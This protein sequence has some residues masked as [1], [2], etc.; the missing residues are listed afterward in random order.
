ME[1][2]SKKIK[3]KS[4]NKYINK[5]KDLIFSYNLDGYIVPKNDEYFSEYA[6]PDRLQKISNFNGSAGLAIILINKN[7]LFVD[8]RYTIQAKKQAGTKFKII[9]IPNSSPKE[10]LKK[11]K[12]KMNL[13]FDPKLFTNI[14]LARNF[15]DSANLLPI[16]VNLIDKIGISKIKEFKNN[17]FYTLP[18]KIVGET[19]NSKINRLINELKNKKVD[20]IFI[21]A[22]ENVA[23]LLNIRGKDNPYSPI[24]NSNLILTKNREIYLFCNK[25]KINKI[26][27]KYIYKKF[28][29]FDPNDFFK[30]INN[31]S[32]N[33][34]CIDYLTCSTYHQFLMS[35]KFKI[36]SYIDPCY[37]MKAIKNNIEI[38]NM[39]KAHEYDGA[40]LTKFLYWIKKNK[41]KNITELSAE[42]KLEIFRRKNKYYISPSFNTI[43]GAGPN[44]AI[45]H[46]KANKKTNRKIFKRDIF[47][48]DSGGQ[49]KYGTTD[50]T[51]TLCFDSPSKKIK[52]RFTRVL[53]G[54][55]AVINTNLNKIKTGKEIDIQARKFLKK[56]NL[57]YSHGTGH[58]VGFY[59]NVHEGPQSISK[60]NQVALKPGMILSN[61]PGYYE[62]NKFGIRI[63][64]LIYIK[65]LKKNIFF[66][67]LT[68]APID[69]DLIDFKLL[70]KNEKNYLNNYHS[71]TYNK[72][73][74]YLNEKEKKWLL[75]LI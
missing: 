7:Y 10:E 65:K 37:T 41:A 53:K 16:S 21:S 45:I 67:N 70:S 18:E 64:N 48:C 56:I 46:Y 71:Q 19:V 3:I 32:G 29:F 44:S 38:N 28:K 30:V 33:N 4:M 69:V 54:H 36:K 9:Q 17:Y 34:F 40:A 61:E 31:L 47:L 51:R 60:F 75:N 52:D 39:I 6:N 13:G 49:Y 62:E 25:K 59:L 63:E 58:G 50:V 27:N 1:K 72:L 57:D 74:K 12:K 20:N 23:W 11:F 35:S 73:A 15:G 55:I 43:A 2:I 5:L 26:I 8:G 68:F 42:K 22:P 24:P 14:S 66:E